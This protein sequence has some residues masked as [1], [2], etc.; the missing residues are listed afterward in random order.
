MNL[1]LHNSVWKYSM[2][3]PMLTAEWLHLVLNFS[4]EY[5]NSRQTII[6]L[7]WKYL[8]DIIEVRHG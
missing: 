5:I 2:L 3:F 7:Y 1:L 6:I 4:P 8:V